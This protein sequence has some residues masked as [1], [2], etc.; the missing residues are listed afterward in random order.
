M[1]EVVCTQASIPDE[2]GSQSP[3]AIP[4]E[5]LPQEPSAMVK[6]S[7]VDATATITPDSILVSNTTDITSENIPARDT[8][9]IPP[10]TNS[11]D[12]T[13]A[14]PCE[15]PT[16]TSADV[17]TPSTADTYSTS[18]TPSK[19]R[20]SRSIRNLRDAKGIALP[21]EDSSFIEFEEDDGEDPVVYVPLDRW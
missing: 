4:A 2:K 18:S 15:E 9:S 6:P 13:Q 7:T 10:A 3:P 19:R 14:I 21:E 5:V 16:T 8:T 17:P 12:K 11:P 1:S 20:K